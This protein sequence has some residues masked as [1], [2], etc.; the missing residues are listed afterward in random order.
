LRVSSSRFLSDVEIEE[1]DE[2]L[3]PRGA[4]MR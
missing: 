4:S 3:Q 2:D 1:Q